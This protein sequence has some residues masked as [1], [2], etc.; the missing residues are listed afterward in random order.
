[1]PDPIHL[2]EIPARI[3]GLAEDGDGY[4]VRVAYAYMGVEKEVTLYVPQLPAAGVGSEVV[5][6]LELRP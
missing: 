5:L 4:A 6:C 3:S 2:T 1:M